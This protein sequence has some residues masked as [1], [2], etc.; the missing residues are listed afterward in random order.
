[1]SNNEHYRMLE[2]MYLQ[3]PIND[4]FRPQITI[5]EGQAEITLPVR[6]DFFHAADA[7]HG[8]LYFKCLDDA[9][10]FA[11]QSLV[12]DVFVLT[13]TFNVYLT[14]PISDGEMRAVGQVVHQSRRL[15]VA[16]AVIRDSEDQEIARGSGSFMLSSIRLSAE[17]GY[18]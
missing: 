8:S 10:F 15:F 4:Y 17:I 13:V 2:R 7:V 6:R 12:E 3:A 9:A 11:V 14:R 16:E 1:M 5:G 18:G